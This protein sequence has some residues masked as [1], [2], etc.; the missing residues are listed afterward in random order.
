M[1]CAVQLQC[2]A[3]FASFPSGGCQQSLYRVWL[4]IFEGMAEVWCITHIWHMSVILMPRWHHYYEPA[5]VNYLHFIAAKPLLRAPLQY[6]SAVISG[7]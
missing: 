3:L 6:S 4:G 2:N 1:V 7:V 5:P